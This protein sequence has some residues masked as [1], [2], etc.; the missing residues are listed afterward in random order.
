VRAIWSFWSRPFELY[1]RHN[2]GNGFNHNLA[3]VISVNA[4]R[5]H[6]PRT[7]L[8]TDSAGK[9]LL[10]DRLGLPFTDVSTELDR[11]AG[12]DPTWWVIG[13]LVAYSMQTEPFVHVDSDAFLWQRLPARLEAAPVLAQHPEHCGLDPYLYRPREVEQAFAAAGGIL[14]P[15]LRWARAQ[16]G[17]LRAENCGI[18]GGHYVPFLRHFAETALALIERPENAAGWRNQPEKWRHNYLVEQYLLA[19]CLDYHRS[20][21]ESPF[22]DVQVNYLFDSWEQALNPS[23]AAR[24]GYTHLMAGAKR[25]ADVVRRMRVRVRRDWPE[26]YQR[27]ERWADAPIG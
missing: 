11:L 23:E 15:E 24:V 6:Y 22:A 14:P 16:G 21:G 8:V 26:F 5:A 25:A 27:C 2:W 1:Y 12:H 18:V 13:K 3:W 10:V 9:R 17:D 7:M 4:A 20:H 19:A